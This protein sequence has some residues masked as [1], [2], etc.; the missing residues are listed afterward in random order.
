MLCHALRWYVVSS[1]VLGFVVVSP[2]L[3][4]AETP[5]GLAHYIMG[6]SYE[7]QEKPAAAVDEYLKSVQ[8]DPSSFA[9][10]MRLGV[11]ASSLGQGR[12]AIDAFIRASRLQP[13]DLQSRYF[14]ALAYSTLRD[15]RRA[16]EQYEVILKAVAA[17]DPGN[18]D[19]H[20]YL[21]QIYYAR[22]K[23]ELAVEQFEKLLVFQPQNTAA[24]LQVGSF[25]LDHGRRDEGRGLLRRC[26]EVDPFEGDCLNALGYSYAED[27]VELEDA[28][29]L[30]KRALEV[31]P[32]NA[33]YL[34]TLGWVYFKQGKLAQ[35]IDTLQQAVLIDKDPAILEHIGDVYQKLGQMDKA[36]A[37]WRQALALDA[38]MPGLSAKIHEARNALG[39]QWLP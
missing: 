32:H 3:G 17:F 33:A 34:D 9:A 10:Q 30:V 13:T 39:S 27:G 2:A 7:F 15:Y 23:F 1:V 24:L 21:A 11:V 38:T 5:Q 36:L 28:R 31:E 25:Y 35:A 18:A 14:L 16:S 12:S 20:M 37:A 22:G 6:V 26:N 8:A 29:H 19:I 4:W